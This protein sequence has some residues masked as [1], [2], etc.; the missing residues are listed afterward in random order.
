MDAVRVTGSLNQYHPIRDYLSG[1][2]WDGDN[3]IEK[4]SSYFDAVYKPIWPTILRKWLIGAVDRVMTGAQNPML[5][6]D[7]PQGCGKSYFARWLCPMP[8]YFREGPID[9]TSRDDKIAAAETWIWEVAELGSTTRKA[10]REALKSFLTTKTF[11]ARASYG[12]N[13]QQYEVISSFLGT[14]NDEAGFLDDPT[15]NRR[16]WVVKLD[17]INPAYSKEINPESIWAEAYAAWANGESHELEEN[18]RIT[19]Q[20]IADEYKVVNATEEAL[21][22]CFIIDPNDP[23]LAGNFVSFNEIRNIL[24][25]NLSGQD[26]SDRKITAALKNLGLE[27]ARKR[28]PLKPGVYSTQAVRGY[29]GL[30]I[31]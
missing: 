25:D 30:E 10:D 31:L 21:K 14:V 3:T 12:H 29:L 17:G 8:R 9:P 26:L 24:S 5:V 6:M 15:G 7:G 11:T 18:E 23:K 1:L 16:F 27:G 13:N 4:L 2:L 20:D 19:M 28:I 22:K